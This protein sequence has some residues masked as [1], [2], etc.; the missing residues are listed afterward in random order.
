M[1]FNKIKRERERERETERKEIV[2]RRV[3]ALLMMVPIHTFTA[4]FSLKENKLFI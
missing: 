1:W 2:H 4:N 3:N